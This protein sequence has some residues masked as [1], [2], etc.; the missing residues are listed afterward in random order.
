V[1]VDRDNLQFNVIHSWREWLGVIV[2]HF[3]CGL[4]LWLRFGLLGFVV[5]VCHCHLFTG[6]PAG[7]K[8]DAPRAL[9]IALSNGRWRQR[10]RTAADASL[11]SN[12]V[13]A[14]TVLV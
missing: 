5:L 8:T 6:A 13:K 1:T 12:L 4:R 14:R 11:R 7:D 9:R 2:V 10:E 3:G